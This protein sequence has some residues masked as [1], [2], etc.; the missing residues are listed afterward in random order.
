[1]PESTI[2]VLVVDD[3][4]TAR[5]MLSLTLQEAGYL[6]REACDGWEA[7]SLIFHTSCRV[8]LTDFQMPRMNGLRLFEYLRAGWP[9]TSIIFMSAGPSDLA[10]A[11]IARGAH[12]WIRKPF[13]DHI[14]LAA[15]NSAIQ[16]ARRDINESEHQR[17][18]SIGL[19]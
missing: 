4:P 12:A 16:F 14:L 17:R 10:E 1:M 5:E 13:A 15:V 6:V 11:I 19:L 18:P 3:D 8:V 9:R 7:L 2:D